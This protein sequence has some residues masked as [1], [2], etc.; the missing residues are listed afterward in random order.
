MDF[1]AVLIESKCGLLSC[2]VLKIFQ[3]NALAGGSHLAMGDTFFFFFDI[4]F[5]LNLVWSRSRAED[6]SLM[7]R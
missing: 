1:H 7:D 6:P 5:N 2:L 4:G 3:M